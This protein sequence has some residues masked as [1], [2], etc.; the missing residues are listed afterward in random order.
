MSMKYLAHL[1]ER[2]RAWAGERVAA[3]PGYF[4]RLAHIQRP[5]LLWIGCSDSRVPANQIVGLEP[6]E[7]FVHRNVANVVPV[8]DLNAM[9][10]IEYAV[11]SLG[12]RHII[13]CG[14]YRCG[15]VRAALEGH[16]AGAVALWLQPLRNLAAAYRRELEVQ[17]SDDARWDRLCELNV[18]AQVQAVATSEIVQAAWERGAELAVHGWIY[19]LED[20]LLRDLEV[21]VGGVAPADG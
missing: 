5:D 2:N 4:S 20:G 18:A 7:L 1:F 21:T 3:D 19:D 9:A 6:G 16:Q 8:T 14:H 12:V 11:S 10:V 15:G 13:V 17:P